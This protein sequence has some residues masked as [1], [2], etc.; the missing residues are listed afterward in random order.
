MTTT[1]GLCRVVGCQN[2]AVCIIVAEPIEGDDE[3]LP[4]VRVCE[5]HRDEWCADG[6]QLVL[7][8]DTAVD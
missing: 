1:L 7:D 4:T 5:K 2:N 3:P 6:W 8:T